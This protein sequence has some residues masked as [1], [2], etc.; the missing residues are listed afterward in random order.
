MQGVFGCT[1]ILLDL[2]KQTSRDSRGRSWGVSLS[3]E[4]Q[5]AK[6]ES[7]IGNHENGAGYSAQVLKRLC[8]LW[9]RT[10]AANQAELL[11]TAGGKKSLVVIV[12]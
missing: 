1:Y 8:L 7:L 3:S 12:L 2:Y 11:R 5:G 10:K 9:I 6:G 4:V